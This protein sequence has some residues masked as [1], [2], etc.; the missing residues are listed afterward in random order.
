MMADNVMVF[1]HCRNKEPHSSG[2]LCRV[3]L[4]GTKI[5]CLSLDKRQ[6][7]N[8]ETDEIKIYLSLDELRV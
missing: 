2:F 6:T 3:V 5:S 8:E 4:S 7:P 1:W